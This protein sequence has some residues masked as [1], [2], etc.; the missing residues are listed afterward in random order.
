MSVPVPASNSDLFYQY[1]D[2][3]KG[4]VKSRSTE[5][6]YHVNVVAEAY[7]K[8]FSDGK[9]S[10]KSEF[11]KLIVSN[12]IEKFSQK[13]NQIYILSKNVISFLEERKF[14]VAGLYINLSP[15]RPSVIISVSN[16]FLN[17]DSFVEIAYSKIYEN[18]NIFTKLFNEPLD[19]GFLSSDNLDEKL[20]K[21][22][23]FGYVEK[24]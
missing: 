24:Y 15:K 5:G 21:E 12:E 13:A 9:K 10:G 6:Y 14:K 1:L 16:E 20:L 4:E 7:N 22:D 8:G 19:I 17:D 3:F 2:S 11:L 23:G 18:K